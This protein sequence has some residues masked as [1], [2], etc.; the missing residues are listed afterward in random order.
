MSKKRLCKV[1]HRP[2]PDKPYR[3]SQKVHKECRQEWKNAKARR[4]WADGKGEAAKKRRRGP[5]FRKQQNAW[6]RE[7]Y[8]EL[9]QQVLDYYGG[10]C[11]CCGE[12]HQEFLAIDHVNGGGRKHR[13][14]TGSGINFYYWIVRNNFPDDLRVLCHNCNQSLGLYGY[15]P[16]QT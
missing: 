4:Q 12:A 5:K 11:E 16:H 13:A 6:M 7:K 2:L 10:C 9:R 1:C 14:K 8:Q 15:C 3:P